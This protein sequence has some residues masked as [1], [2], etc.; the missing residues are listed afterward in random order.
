MSVAPS[1]ALPQRASCSGETGPQS[2][3]VVICAYTDRRW[4][5]LVQ[6]LESVA[7][8]RPPPAETIVVID[9]NEALLERAQ[10]AFCDARVIPNGGPRGLSAARNTGV[11]AARQ[12]IVVFLDDDARAAPGWLAALL[13]PFGD[14]G[15]IGSG[16]VAL[17]SWESAS[18]SWL[19]AEFL[20]VVGCSYRGL[21]QRPAAIRNPIGANMA[22]RRSVL[23]AVGGFDARI[24][25]LGQ[26][27]LG[28]EE[29]ELSIRARALTGGRVLHV[30]GA[31]V[32]HLVG[33]ERTSWAYFRRRCFAEG[34]SKARVRSSVGTS[35]A[36][37]SERAYVLRTLPSGVLRGLRAGLAGEPSGLL[38][39]GAILAGLAFTA[40]GY[41]LALARGE[42]TAARRA[43]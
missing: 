30:P 43:A 8:Q 33:A 18:P 10:A 14:P 1:T 41:L 13:E 5:A 19:P 21:P 15:V 20:W 9:H 29:T 40:G 37:S 25:R 42:R 36:L 34:V 28:C 31:R 12:E 17:A 22:F 32:S 6:A 16:G 38:R 26:I 24:G 7:A 3:S 11:A 23:V 2:A 4:P 39:T 27:P 35:A